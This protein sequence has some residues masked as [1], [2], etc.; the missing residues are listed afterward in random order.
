MFAASA[1][2]LRR[3]FYLHHTGV[4]L[5]VYVELVNLWYGVAFPYAVYFKGFP[6]PLNP[7]CQSTRSLAHCN[8]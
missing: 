3:H 5:Y 7:F 1:S 6:W 4:I 2:E 8:M